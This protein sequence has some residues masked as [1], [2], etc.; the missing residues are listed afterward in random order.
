MSKNH[1]GWKSKKGPGYVKSHDACRNGVSRK[2]LDIEPLTDEQWVEK[3]WKP[4]PEVDE[5]HVYN[6]KIAADKIVFLPATINKDGTVE[7]MRQFIVEKDGPEQ[8]HWGERADGKRI[9]IEGQHNYKRQMNPHTHEHVTGTNLMNRNTR[10]E[11]QGD[12]KRNEVTGKTYTLPSKNLEVEARISRYGR[13]VNVK[14]APGCASARAVERALQHVQNK[15]AN[16]FEGKESK[17][18]NTNLAPDNSIVESQVQ[19]GAG[20]TISPVGVEAHV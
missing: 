12:K 15:T 20:S 10:L 16:F 14:K 1:K 5:Q 4:A 17:N 7:N 18:T 9:W 2:A 11:M 13:T 6:M 8:G 19:S 3:G